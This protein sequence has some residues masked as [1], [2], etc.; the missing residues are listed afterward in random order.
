MAIYG[1]GASTT[2]SRTGNIY[3]PDDNPAYNSLMRANKETK[4][5]TNPVTKARQRK[6]RQNEALARNTHRQQAIDQ[7]NYENSRDATQ[8]SINNSRWE[9][10]AGYD[11]A[12]GLYDNFRNELG[13]REEQQRTDISQNLAAARGLFN[14]QI[15]HGDKAGNWLMEGMG[16]PNNYQP[17]MVGSLADTYWD[18]RA[19]KMSDARSNAG[20]NFGF[21]NQVR[22]EE[23][24]RMS[25]Q[26]REDAAIGRRQNDV[27][28]ASNFYNAGNAGRLN[29]SNLHSAEGT[30]LSNIGTQYSNY[31]G[32]INNSQAN[33]AL[34][35]G[36][37]NSQLSGAEGANTSGYF[38]KMAGISRGDY[39]WWRNAQEAD[40][41]WTA[42]ASLQHAMQNQQMEAQKDS[43]K[44]SLF[45]GLAGG[46]AKMGASFLTGGLST[47]LT[48]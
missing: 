5:A 15:E 8:R 18:D 32:N 33:N 2:Q 11:K 20:G 16:D 22:G 44:N 1:G 21:T 43:S 14:Q 9:G 47:I 7:K 19:Q 4:K 25:M 34:N 37:F 23:A 41:Q 48:G 10:N 42:N 26:G 38:N 17:Y 39:D 12:Q 46:A 27:N 29:Q 6:Q 24:R 31:L 13:T 40:N 35:R 28:V 45:A 3:D 30:A 36:L